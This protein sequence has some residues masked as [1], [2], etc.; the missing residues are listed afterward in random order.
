MITC[1]C[2]IRN[3]NY[4]EGRMGKK[5][6]I[7]RQLM[8]K[9]TSFIIIIRILCMGLGILLARTIV[10]ENSA[11]LLSNFAKETG[12]NISNIIE[13]EIQNVE[14]I[15]QTP[16][17]HSQNAEEEKMAYLKKIT[18][19]YG[20]KKA[21]LID[22]QG[23]CKTIN[24]E[25]VNV[26]E[27][28][29]FKVNMKGESFLTAP[30][31]SKADGGLQIAIS[32]PIITDNKIVGVLFFS[33]DARQFS[34]ITN[35]LSFGKTGT[36]YVVDEK[37]TNIINRDIDKVINKVNRLQD[38]KTMPEYR[39]LA[40]IT[41]KMIRG[42]SGTGT[43]R[44]NGKK[45]FLG[46]APVSAK[47]WAVGVTVEME[48]MLSGLKRIALYLGIF[49]LLI[50]GAMLLL[51]YK[52]AADFKNR[53]GYV[54]DELNQMVQGNL[55]INQKNYNIIDEISEIDHTLQLAKMSLTEMMEKMQLASEVRKE[56][57]RTDK[58]IKEMSEHKNK[59]LS[60]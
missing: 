18:D 27:L 59:E 49:I 33:K 39:E 48:D 14:M 56:L 42:E 16:I 41:E 31:H 29:Y 44:L 11:V 8:I 21:A 58:Q 43:Y 51:T 17:L 53:L 37:G 50:M 54:Q 47:G 57:L 23:N 20:Y 13:L 30:Y 55:T 15:A 7:K 26:A 60:H 25:V 32:T 28:E 38:A 5:R 6:D 40:A 9:Y 2:M 10:I 36:A 12:K 19:R 45:K 46:Y 52:I 4:K 22:L 35:E 3:S 1:N 34:M 24:G